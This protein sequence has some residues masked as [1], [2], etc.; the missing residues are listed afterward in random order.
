[1]SAVRQQQP[2]DNPANLAMR[3]RAIFSSEFSS[4]PLRKLRSKGIPSIKRARVTKV[5]CSS[6]EECLES[7]AVQQAHD[8]ASQV[9]SLSRGAS[10]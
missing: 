1:M 8:L 10:G 6:L 4:E 7:Q 9:T 3:L 5:K 2:Q